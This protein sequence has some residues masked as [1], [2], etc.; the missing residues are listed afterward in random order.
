M[1]RAEGE[2]VYGAGGE[3]CCEVSEA[4]IRKKVKNAEFYD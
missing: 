4:N 1:D 3:V 2:G